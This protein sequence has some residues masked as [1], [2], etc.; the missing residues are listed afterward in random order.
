MKSIKFYYKE[1][2]LKIILK[3]L[4]CMAMFAKFHLIL[5]LFEIIQPYFNSFFFTDNNVN[6]DDK[7]I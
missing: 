4:K 2:K 3:F 6:Q 1:S 5:Y 7:S